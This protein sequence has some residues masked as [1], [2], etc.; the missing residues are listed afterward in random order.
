MGGYC[1]FFS[2]VLGGPKASAALGLNA[3]NRSPRV[4][5]RS[6]G[7]PLGSVRSSQDPERGKVGSRSG[8]SELGR[9]RGR[10]GGTPQPRGPL[11]APPPR[12]RPLPGR[13]PPGSRD[14]ARRPLG[15]E[16]AARGRGGLGRRGGSLAGRSGPRA[17]EGRAAP[18]PS[19]PRPGRTRAPLAAPP[20]AR[21]PLAG[22]RR[23]WPATPCR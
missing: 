10:A 12:P 9:L 14:R 1:V 6:N 17:G 8:C 22:G 18:A 13:R 21:G 2:G 5:A 23:T 16:G 11:G 4:P 3:R 7:G 20:S 19:P 15:L